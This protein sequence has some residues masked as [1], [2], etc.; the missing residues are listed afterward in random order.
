MT[1][2]AA[3]IQKNG[4]LSVANSISQEQNGSKSAFQFVDKRPEAI[5]QRQLQDMADNSPQ[6]KQLRAFQAV[7]ASDRAQPV[8]KIE[9]NTGLPDQLKI[10]LESISGVSLDDVKVHPNSDK[11]AQLDA[12]AYAQGS[13][14]HLG[15]GQETHLPHEAWHVVQQKQGRVKP[16]IQVK[17]SV[18]VNDDAE[19]ENEA[20]VM[21]AKALQKKHATATAAVVNQSPMNTAQR[22]PDDGDKYDAELSEI[23]SSLKTLQESEE[24]KA[25]P[26]EVEEIARYIEQASDILRGADARAKQALIENAKTGSSTIHDGEQA[27]AATPELQM[28]A[29]NPMPVQRVLGLALGLTVAAGIGYGIYRIIQN[30]ARMP[31]P[32]QGIQGIPTTRAGFG[33]TLRLGGLTTGEL[34][35]EEIGAEVRRRTSRNHDILF[36]QLTDDNN[37]TNIAQLIQNVRDDDSLCMGTLCHDL[38]RFLIQ[39]RTTVRPT[40]EQLQGLTGANEIQYDLN[41]DDSL[42]QILAG[43]LPGTSVYLGSTEAMSGHTF[44]VVGV[45]RG[46]VI[47]ADRQPAN[48]IAALK[49]AST[50]EAEARLSR[51][52]HPDQQGAIDREFS[53]R[54]ILNQF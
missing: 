26:E 12:H 6:V 32:A 47:V 45:N 7:S 46:R 4:S 10:G 28:K 21:G 36:Q 9:N 11:P 41:S 2:C 53:G 8:Q 29:A 38:T 18:N 31:A 23:I 22:K 40:I 44:T 49:Y 33:Q 20:D 16:T 13:D 1:T 42:E 48:P 54:L 43:A 19:L 25:D 34:S 14:I 52:L 24:V 3:K 37:V 51:S 50:V 30:R 39:Q 35:N 27:D 15:P 5:A 17:G